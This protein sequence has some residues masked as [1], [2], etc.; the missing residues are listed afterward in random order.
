MSTTILERYVTPDELAI[1][2]EDLFLDTVEL[3]EGLYS[4]QPQALEN[5]SLVNREVISSTKTDTVVSHGRISLTDGTVIKLVEKMKDLDSRDTACFAYVSAL[6]GA[7]VRIDDLLFDD[8]FT[9]LGNSEDYLGRPAQGGLNTPKTLPLI[10][11]QTEVVKNMST[12]THDFRK[13]S[14]GAKCLIAS[15]AVI[16]V[17]LGASKEAAPKNVD[18]FAYKNSSPDQLSNLTGLSQALSVKINSPLTKTT[19]GSTDNAG[20]LKRTVRVVASASAAPRP[21]SSAPP[22]YVS[23][24]VETA[25]LPT[26]DLFSPEA[27]AADLV[28]EDP[29][30]IAPLLKVSVPEIATIVPYPVPEPITSK[31]PETIPAPVNEAKAV[32]VPEVMVDEPIKAPVTTKPEPNPESVP[33]AVQPSPTTNAPEVVPSAKPE[34]APKIT[35]PE[36]AAKKESAAKELEKKD[37][38]DQV[39]APTTKAPAGS[40][41]TT[42][43]TQPD[44]AVDEA[45]KLPEDQPTESEVN[46]EETEPSSISDQPKIEEKDSQEVTEDKAEQDDAKKSEREIAEAKICDAGIDKG[47]KPGFQKGESKFLKACRV[48]NLTVNSEVA[49]NVQDMLDAAETVGIN[50]DAHPASSYRSHDDQ[51]RLRKKHC[52]GEDHVYDKEAHCTPPTAIPGNSQHE[53][54]LAIDFTCDGKAVSK[55]GECFKWLQENAAKYGF[56]NLPSEPWHWSTTGR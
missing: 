28:K 7:E 53:M 35:E 36:P 18:S 48:G 22:T 39:E 8:I 52:G 17:I 27:Q 24:P 41:K 5:V 29:T 11:Y 40:H 38:F 21:E 56:Y 19:S 54:G 3:L 25:A 14:K 4:G 37:L 13:P 10:N 16:S 20:S 15:V 45:S 43:T 9:I 31:A 32:I 12:E 34:L 33:E 1:K 42:E 55:D 26:S 49:K 23:I 47:V 2:R 30:P 50:L 44:A 46:G 51:I 6:N